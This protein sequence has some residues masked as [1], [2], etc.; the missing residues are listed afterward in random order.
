MRKLQVV[1]LFALAVVSTCSSV[2]ELT[3][4]NFNFVERGSWLVE[5]Y[6]PWCQ[7]CKKLAP[8]WEEVASHYAKNDNKVKVGKVDCEAQSSVCSKA[9]VEGYPTIKYY[10]HGLQKNYVGGRK[11]HDFINYVH[12]I[13][14][15]PTIE[16]TSANAATVYQQENPTFV[17]VGAQPESEVRNTFVEL[18][19][20]MLDLE[21]PDFYELK[22]KSLA[23]EHLKDVAD[24]S[25]V[26]FREGDRIVYPGK[27]DL[28]SML[29]WA[30]HYRFPYVSKY[31]EATY[32][33]L[34]NSEKLLVL[35]VADSVDV[36]EEKFIADFKVVAKRRADDKRYLFAFLDALQYDKYAASFG[37]VHEVLPTVVVLD[38]SD[39]IH[40]IDPSIKFSSPEKIEQFLQEIEAGNVKSQTW[41]YSAYIAKKINKF[42]IFVWNWVKENVIMF[43]VGSVIF[44]V[45]F[46]FVCCLPTSTE[47]RKTK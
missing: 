27:M 24:Q 44:L 37:A 35:A 3:D 40:Y 16:L 29:E 6:A 21:S 47:T 4:E 1:I 26:V 7:H 32:E 2:I 19:K 8:V 31:S 20:H 28:Q 39:E 42:S 9:N 17:L 30:K 34:T 12:K 25:L 23:G 45:L 18:A 38:Q 43:S 36:E 14:K 10:V 46:V 5:F 13:N 33:A 22:D 15:P 11:K 41:S